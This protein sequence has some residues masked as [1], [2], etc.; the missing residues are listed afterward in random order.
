MEAKPRKKSFTPR[1]GKKTSFKP[2]GNLFY[3]LILLYYAVRSPLI[4]NY[5]FCS[6][7]VKNPDHSLCSGICLHYNALISVFSFI[8]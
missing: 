5:Q 3:I 6:V 1:D 7:V 4:L 8:R 2:K